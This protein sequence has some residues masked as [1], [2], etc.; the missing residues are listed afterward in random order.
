MP[1]PIVS[2][3]ILAAN[4]ACLGEECK[5]VVDGGAEWLHIDVMDGHFVPNLS[6]GPP[7]IECLRKHSGNNT[8]FDVHLMITQP[9]KCVEIYSKVGANGYTFHFEAMDY[10]EEMRSIYQSI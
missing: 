4:F 8:Y 2:P 1:K 6:L 5:R 3:S 9:R 10:L 7:V